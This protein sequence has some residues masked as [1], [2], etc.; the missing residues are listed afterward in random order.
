MPCQQSKIAASPAAPEVLMGHR[1]KCRQQLAPRNGCARLQPDPA[2]DGKT[3][4]G[5]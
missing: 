1:K 3:G 5:T 4:S 2:G